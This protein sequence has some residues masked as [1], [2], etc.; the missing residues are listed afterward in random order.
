[1]NDL[2]DQEG[3][4]VDLS[5]QI[6]KASENINKLGTL[7]TS[8]KEVTDGASAIITADNAQIKSVDDQ[9]AAIRT[10]EINALNASIEALKMLPMQF[11][12][13]IQLEL[14]LRLKNKL[15]H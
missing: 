9:L 1:M 4:F 6:E 15:I 10:K 2:Q 14:K 12:K 11:Q 5:N 7:K 13:M 8:F 3:A